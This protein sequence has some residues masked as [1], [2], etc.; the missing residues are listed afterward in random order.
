MQKTRDFKKRLIASLIVFTIVFS[1]FGTLF[2]GLIAF[3]AD[4]SDDTITYA[5]QFV[6][7]TK[8]D[9][10]NQAENKQN[11]N[12]EENSLVTIEETFEKANE[13]IGAENSEEEKNEENVTS[14]TA[15]RSEENVTSET[16]EGRSEENVTSEVA[17]ERS[18][19]NV[20]SEVAEER[21]NENATSETAERRSEENVTSETA[22]GRSEGNGTSETG[23]GRSEENVT[24]ETAEEKIEL[25]RQEEKSEE[26]K[27]DIQLAQGPAIEIKLGVKT[28]GYLKNA[29]IDVKD[30][31]NQIFDLREDF[32]LGEYVQSIENGKIRL[33]QING[34]T[35]VTIYIPIKLKD[36]EAVNIKK[37]QEG[38]EIA[39]IGTYVDK[40][41]NE[42]II[43]KSVKPVYDMSNDINLVVDANIEKFIPYI[44][45]ER[46][47]ALL[48]LK[49]T[50]DSENKPQLPV[51]DTKIEIEIPEVEGSDIKDV[52]VSAISTGFTN[53]LLNGDVLFTVENW[54]YENGIITINVNNSDKGGRYQLPSGK[55][56][57]IIS[58]IYENSAGIENL[59]LNTK[60]NTNVNVFTSKDNKEISNFVEKEYDLSQAN[61]NIITYDVTRR[62]PEFS[63]GYLYANANAAKPEYIVEY[64]NAF[65]INVSRIDLVNAIQIDEGL[66]YFVDA[67]NRGYATKTESG[68]NTYYEKIR[69]NKENLD[70]IIGDEGDFEI[71]LD[72]GTSLI[73]INKE[74][75]DDGDGYITIS[76]GE[77]KIGKISMRINNPSGEGFLNI[78]TTKAISNIYYDK[79]DLTQFQAIGEMFKGYVELD[80]GIIS[81]MGEIEV[82]TNLVE[83]TTNATVTL[84]RNDLSTLVE[85][86][87]VEINISLNNATDESDMFKNPVFELVFPREIKEVTLKDIN[88]VYGNDELEI[89]NVETIQNNEGNVVLRITLEGAQSK[90]TMGDSKNGTTIMLKTNIK[91]DM[92]TASRKEKIRLDYYNEDATIY[93]YSDEWKM[94]AE[95]SS[96]MLSVKQGIAEADLNIVAPEGFVN[97]QMISEYKDGKT[98]ISVDQGRKEDTIK[99]FADARVAEMKMIVIN[100]TNSDMNNVHILGR[101]IFSGNKSVI[102]KEELGTNQTAPMISKIEAE[103]GN[104]KQKIYYSENGEAT[105]DLKLQGN[106]W[107]ET[108]ENLETIRSYLIVIDGDVK[109]GDILTYSYKFRIPEKLTNNI[110]LSG[111]FGTYYTEKGSVKSVEADKVVLTTGDAPVLKVETISDADSETV[112]GGQRVKYTVKVTN[113]GRS[114][115]TNTVVNSIIPAGTT[116]VENGIL[117]PEVTSLN[118]E[119]GDLRPGKTEEITYE[120]E[121]NKSLGS[122]NVIE[123]D[124]N[125]DADGLEEPIY[126]DVPD[127]AVDT[128]ELQV[129]I[130]NYLE[131]GRTIRQDRGVWY[132]VNVVN[133]SNKEIDDCTVQVVL[134]EGLEYED[135]Y[136]I[137]S[138]EDGLTEVSAGQASYNRSSRVVT[139]HTD[140]INTSTAF[141]LKTKTSNISESQKDIVLYATVKSPNLKREYVSGE[142]K[143][144]VAKPVIEYSYKSSTNNKFIKEGDQI[145]YTLDIKN[146]GLIGAENINIQSIVPENYK[147]VGANVVKDSSS[148]SAIPQNNVD[149]KVTLE[150]NESARVL[151][152]CVVNNLDDI[153][154]NVLTQNSWTISGDGMDT[155]N[156]VAVQNIIQQNYELTNNNNVINDT[157]DDNIAISNAT[158]QETDEIELKINEKEDISETIGNS[159][160][161]ILGKAYSDLNNNGRFDEDELGMVNIVAKLCDAKTQ[162]MVSHAVTN[163]SGEYIFDNV[164]PG[165]YY[166]KFE[167][168]T[169]KYTIS[170]YQKQGVETERNSDAVISNYKTVTD[171]IV[172]KDTS[173]SGIDIGLVRAGIFDLDLD[174]NVNTMTL[175]DDKETK[176]Y[177]IE[178]SKLGKVDINP[179]TINETKVFVEY[180]IDVTNRGEIAGYAKS[181][182]DYIP[183]GLTFDGQLNKNWYLGS[184]GKVYNTELSDTI[185]NPGEIKTIKLVLTKQ[186][187]ENTTGLISNTFE[188]DKDYNEYAISDIDSTPGNQ[189]E[190][191]DDMSRADIIIGI[192]TGGSLINVMI[193]STTLITLLIA[194]YVVKLQIDKRNKEVI[195]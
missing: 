98:L 109:V 163:N 148:T 195:V 77:N 16:A 181:I 176:S 117:K 83:T 127:T 121:V 103:K 44:V 102:T 13:Q 60:V 123:T 76:F 169:T 88:L 36:E 138:A 26:N 93:N 61:S 1:N 167:Y 72:N 10:Q 155:V 128:A 41:G 78:V 91:L 31:E 152:N 75:P 17:E 122:E 15:G 189:A 164:N 157:E 45:D 149:L 139:W 69:L 62:T 59:V 40:D 136:V 182:V 4:S 156:T 66:E 160:Y 132:T 116:Y 129:T 33:K 115:S 179:Q 111:T 171:K 71:L 21:S 131:E 97:S 106:G 95:P 114:I 43:T 187:N 84:S 144:T 18:N 65:D 126:T 74:T 6:M 99:T 79:T 174:V 150:S 63:K 158:T 147:V 145:D 143:N 25:N 118:I 48:Q 178:N 108:P 29:K 54:S 186:M 30:L 70:S 12:S 107:T 19:E 192:Q 134:P 153:N 57:Y 14:E 173:I 165:E 38:V 49:V 50:V 161:K 193:I 55:D 188:I 185:I 89:S 64:E 32:S 5:A 67:Y 141:K 130:N 142:I 53:G 39:L 68:E 105:D 92:Y 180:T 146:T 9:D 162:K 159:S 86:D 28:S 175:Q 56:E 140:K 184:D 52:R 194:L 11:E 133:M 120:V 82:F 113:E 154:N 47:E 90:Y 190:G 168:D 2:S 27:E 58:Y 191:E 166:V 20:T 183:E 3:A 177:E 35:E 80:E 87:D 101:T 23:E 135:G 73:K 125:V 42:S 110:D 22:E 37:L 170:E 94:I 119:I 7:I 81:E 85:N 151:L 34:G 172:V 137:G 51:K 8:T 96:Y 24:S 112:V 124:N 46:N 104:K 100:N